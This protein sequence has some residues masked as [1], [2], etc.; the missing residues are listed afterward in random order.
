MLFSTKAETGQITERLRIASDG[1]IG[2]GVTNPSHTLHVVGN[3]K[4]QGDL[5]VTGNLTYDNVTN[6]DAVGVITA[7]NGISVTGAGITVTGISTFYNDVDF[8]SGIGIGKSIFHIGDE[9]TRMQFPTTN[10][11]GGSGQEIVFEANNTERL[12]INSNG[13]NL[14]GSTLSGNNTSVN[15]FAIQSTDGNTNRSQI[16]IGLI[17]GNDGG[18]IHFYTTGD[19]N[20]DTAKAKRMVIKGKTGNIGIGETDPDNTFTVKGNGSGLSLIHI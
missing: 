2:I 7:Q 14:R 19:G 12:L 15:Y 1:K 18:G 9:G 3:T 4:I 16:D 17:S 20:V 11:N 6:I 5:D 13:V 8:N 10:S